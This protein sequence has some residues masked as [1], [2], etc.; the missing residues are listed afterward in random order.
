MEVLPGCHDGELARTVHKLDRRK[1]PKLATVEIE[2]LQNGD[3]PLGGEE[4]GE[5]SIGRLWGSLESMSLM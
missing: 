3:R 1:R 4:W 5:I 2:R